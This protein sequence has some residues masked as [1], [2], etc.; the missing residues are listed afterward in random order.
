MRNIGVRA[1]LAASGMPNPAPPSNV[2]LGLG[3]LIVLTCAFPQIA[4]ILGVVL[5]LTLMGGA[6]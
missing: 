2:M 4:L 3:G 1:G 5:V 6:R